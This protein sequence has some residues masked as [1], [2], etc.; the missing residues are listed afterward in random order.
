MQRNFVIDWS[1]MKDTIWLY[2][3]VQNA[4]LGFLYH[5]FN[6]SHHR[7]VCQW[8]IG[9]SQIDAFPVWRAWALALVQMEHYAQA[10]VK[11][12]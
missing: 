6:D 4:R 11:L 7:T 5:S 9:F 12:K 2:I 10:R 8:S 3:V 1:L